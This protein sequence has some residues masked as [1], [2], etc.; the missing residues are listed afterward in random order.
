MLLHKSN[1]TWA[2]TYKNFFL[3]ILMTMNKM[4]KIDFKCKIRIVSTGKGTRN[5]KITAEYGIGKS[6]I[7]GNKI[8]YLKLDKFRVHTKDVNNL[9]LI[10]HELLT[11]LFYKEE[12]RLK[13]Y[14][15]DSHNKSILGLK[16]CRIAKMK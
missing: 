14:L 1:N 10:Q 15:R 5:R 4:Y 8:E 3:H 6:N 16:S 7:T 9:K 13:D 12:S 2:V 11:E